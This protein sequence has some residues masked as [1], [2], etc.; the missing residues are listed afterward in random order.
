M[1]LRTFLIADVRGY[2]RFTQEHGDEAASALAAWFAG[3]VRGV[4]PEFGGELLELRGD[5]ALCVFGSARQ[6]LRASVALQRRLRVAGDAERVFPLG[7]GIG[8]DAGE[9][10]P[11]E[12][13][14]RG[15]ALNIASRVCAQARPGQILASE[16]VVSLSSRVDGVRFGERRLLRAKG[17][18]EPIR[19][20]EVTSDQPLPPL[21]ILPRQQSSPRSRR[22]VGAAA[23]VVAA[24]A[25]GAIVLLTGSGRGG[26]AAVRIRANSIVVLDPATKQIVRD[27]PLDSAPGALVAA[28][29]AIWAAEESTSSVERIDLATLRRRSVGVGIDPAAMAAD[30]SDMW[31]Y[32]GAANTVVLV[33]LSLRSAPQPIHPLPPCGTEMIASLPRPHVCFQG[34]IAFGDG[35]VWIGRTHRGASGATNPGSVWRIN[36][37]NDRREGPVISRLPSDQLIFGGGALWAYG[38]YGFKAA[39]IDPVTLRVHSFPIKSINAVYTQPGLTYGFGYTWL[40]SP[41][42][43]TFAANSSGVY[44]TIPVSAGAG[45]VAAG[46]NSVWVTSLNGT[47]TQIDPYTF[48]VTKVYHLHHAASG[49]AYANR[50]LWIAVGQPT[51]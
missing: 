29:N 27:V 31:V 2:T 33:D 3:I 38:A 4:M 30:S 24:I 32:D 51:S 25:A 20:V 7:V 23:V 18:A 36:P 44:R 1:H 16:T 49:I 9:A 50:H 22:R 40:V 37:S 10:V 45:A 8:L 39:R 6:A 43:D 42:G 5:E 15:Q 12:G 17:I 28:G 41:N 35:S 26:Q 46:A 47:V 19:V 34:G 11:T 48:T 14:Y 21:P 13:G